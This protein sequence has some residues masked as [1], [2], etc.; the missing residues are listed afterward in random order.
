MWNC[1]NNEIFVIGPI[2][3]TLGVLLHYDGRFLSG[4]WNLLSESN[5]HENVHLFQTMFGVVYIAKIFF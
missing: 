2:I 1:P 5:F 4:V 3:L